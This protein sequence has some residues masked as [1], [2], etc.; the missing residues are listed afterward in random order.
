MKKTILG[1]AAYVAASF[2]VQA[3]SHFALFKSHFD[4]IDFARKEPIMLPGVLVML[5]QGIVLTYLY[6]FFHKQEKPLLRGWQ[7]GMLVGLFLVSYIAIV[8]PSKYAVPSYSEW[9]GVE[10][11][12]GLVQFSLFGLAL[13]WIFQK[14]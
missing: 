1:T 12:A 14:K 13:G 2:I 7:F 11:L 5:V 9:V 10:S 6:Q 4:G 3:T 8:E